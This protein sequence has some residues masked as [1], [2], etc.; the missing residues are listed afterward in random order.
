[1]ALWR[2]FLGGDK[3]T[4][5]ASALAPQMQRRDRRD[6]L[7][8]LV[9]ETLD[10]E[11]AKLRPVKPRLLSLDREGKQFMVLL[12]LPRNPKEDQGQASNLQKIQQLLMTQQKKTP[13]LG[14]RSVYWTFTEDSRTVANTSHTKDSAAASV[15]VGTAAVEPGEIPTE[16]APLQDFDMSSKFPLL[17][18][19]FDRPG[20][21]TSRL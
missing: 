18:S 20:H 13:D 14:L 9:Q 21:S 2:S 3:N 15:K 6:V 19:D 12:E 16:L 11:G 17:G 8:K 1:M 5:A 10:L 4:S 7:E